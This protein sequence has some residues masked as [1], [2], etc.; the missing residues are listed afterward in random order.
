MLPVL[1]A[2]LGVS[3]DEEQCRSWR[4]G[5][6]ILL[7]VLGQASS[8]ALLGFAS[9]SVGVFVLQF[10]RGAFLFLGAVSLLI[11]LALLNVFSLS[12]Q[13]GP[14]TMPKY[15]HSPVSAFLL[16]FVF[17]L[18]ASPCSAPLLAAFLALAA[19]TA[20]A[21][22]GAGLLFVYGLG[23]G[24]SLLMAGLLFTGLQRLRSWAHLGSVVR[25]LAGIVFILMGLYY[26]HRAVW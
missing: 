24:V 18:A 7:F 3:W 9:G 14:R 26:I 2:Y 25:Q 23:Q 4:Q 12:W 5:S 13:I 22:Q 1:L 10:G 20:S 8:L 6:R 11:G 17:A 21:W 16:G 19:N 15:G